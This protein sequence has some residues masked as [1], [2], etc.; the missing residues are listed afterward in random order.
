[1]VCFWVFL[2]DSWRR[3]NVKLWEKDMIFWGSVTVFRCPPDGVTNFVWDKVRSVEEK[4]EG[5][6]SFIPDI[7]SC[8]S[9]SLVSTCP[10]CK[11]GAFHRVLNWRFFHLSGAL[12]KPWLRTTNVS[13]MSRSYFKVQ[14]KWELGECIRN[15][16]FKVGFFHNISLCLLEPNN[17]VSWDYWYFISST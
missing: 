1:M 2:H 6:I 16:I 12:D 15:L 14:F 10:R 8:S 9:S 13:K 5:D 3:N 17:H 11:T 7:S 4:K